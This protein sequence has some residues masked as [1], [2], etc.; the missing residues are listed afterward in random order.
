LLTINGDTLQLMTPKT[1]ASASAA[2][3]TGQIAWDASHI[4]VCTAPD[5]WVRAALAT[6]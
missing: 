6:W 3:A 1:P 4:Y 2:G 5:T